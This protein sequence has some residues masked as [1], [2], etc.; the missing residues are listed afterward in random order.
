MTGITRAQYD[1]AKQHMLD[2]PELYEVKD[3]SD[4]VLANVA[5]INDY[6]RET[7]DP[8]APQV[9]PDGTPQG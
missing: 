5:L 7:H 4:E 2:H 6:D 9:W 3:P 8:S 1:Q